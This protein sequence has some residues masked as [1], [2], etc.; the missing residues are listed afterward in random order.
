MTIKDFVSQPFHYTYG[1]HAPVLRVKSGDTIEV[2]CPS[3]DNRM[4]DGSP[5]KPEHRQQSTG[6]P[7]FEGNPLAGPICVDGLGVGD[8]LAIEIFDVTIQGEQGLTLLAP[9]HGLLTSEELTDAT[10]AEV[11]EQMYQWQI[12]QSRKT[13]EMVNP[14]GPDYISVPLRPMVGSIGVCPS[15][16]QHISS[17]FAG[18]FGGNLDLSIVRSGATIILPVFHEGGLLYLGDLHAAQGHG[19]IVGG[20]IE[21]SGRVQLRVLKVASHAVSAPLVFSEDCIYAVATDGDV[22]HAISLAYSRLLHWLTNTLGMNR[23]DTYQLLSQV[24]TLEL[25]GIVVRPCFTV[26]ACIARQRLPQNKQ[27]EVEEWIGSVGQ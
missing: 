2:L 18:D 11:P 10:D 23:W 12:D 7:L 25:G 21:V 13:A 22:R 19:E 9:R 5:I 24:G 4:A 27:S 20:A 17:L 8:S 15:S 3:G 16:G 6:A 1:P 14:L 26:A